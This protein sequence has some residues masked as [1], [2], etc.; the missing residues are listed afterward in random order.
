VEEVTPAKPALRSDSGASVYEAEIFQEVL[1]LLDARR[2]AVNLRS[3]QRYPI[4]Q[5]GDALM[6]PNFDDPYQHVR[7]N[8][9]VAL[10]FIYVMLVRHD[11]LLY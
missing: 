11:D 2:Y 7:P 8:M 10:T 6:P 1:R 3:V 4:H 5:P 9:A